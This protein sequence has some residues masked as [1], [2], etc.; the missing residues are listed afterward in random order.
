MDLYSRRIIGWSF[1]RQRNADLTASALKMALS[2]EP[3]TQGCIFHSDQGIEYAAHEYRELV[4]P[5]GLVRSMSRKG[6]QLDNATVESYFHTLKAELVHQVRFKNPIE[7]TAK[8]MS[9]IEFYN[10]DRVHTSIGFQ[11]RRKYEKLCA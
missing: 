3:V 8:I 11:S 6:T 10:R 9:Y 4:E 7:A 5:A 2:Q 1:A